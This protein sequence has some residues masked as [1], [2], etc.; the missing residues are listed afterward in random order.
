MPAFGTLLQTSGWQATALGDQRFKFGIGLWSVG[1]ESRIRHLPI[2][3]LAR[4]DRIGLSFSAPFRY[5]DTVDA[6][7]IEAEHLLL[8]RR[9]KLRVAVRLNQ[10]RRDL[11]ASEGLD[12]V[13]R[14][15]VPKCVRAP[16]HIILADVRKELA[17]K[18][19]GSGRIAHDVAPGRAKL[20]I[21]VGV[22]ADAVNLHRLDQSIDAAGGVRRIIG[23]LGLPAS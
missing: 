23:A 3:L 21:D 10:C 8:E 17:K 2:N 12:L 11:K 22:P 9:R 5:V 4:P 13:L 6:S 18:V 19:R 1:F 7:P 16:E 14:R 15:A 20:G